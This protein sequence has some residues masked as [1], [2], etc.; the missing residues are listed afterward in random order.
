M[1]PRAH[2]G[3]FA[4]LA[5]SLPNHSDELLS[6]ILGIIVQIPF[7]RPDVPIFNTSPM[8][9][10]LMAACI[11]IH[12]VIVL[13]PIPIANTIIE[14]FAFVA[15]R[16][17]VAGAWQLDL[18]AFGLGPFTHMFLHGGFIH[19]LMNLAMLLAFGT[20]I[21][22]RMSALSF[23]LFYTVCGLAGALMLGAFHPSSVI[24]LLGASGAISGMAGAVGRI[25]LTGG[26]GNGMPFRSRSAAFAF[27]VLWLVFNFIFGIIGP[28]IF[29]MQGD[30]AWEAHLGGFIAGFV[31]VNLFLK[32]K[33]QTGL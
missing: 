3:K 30:I 15:A 17:T 28:A 5:T 19:L 18:I 1:P 25:S 27:V 11:I 9:G 33:S 20:P 26:P 10:R 6:T 32:A 14:R 7:K 2:R 8:V 21:E 24:P 13:L 23:A 22:R 4:A 12:L 16:Y 31:L 29:G